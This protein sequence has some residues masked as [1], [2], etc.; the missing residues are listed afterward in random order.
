[1]AAII[2]ESERPAGAAPKAKIFISYSR[3]DM[4][5][6]DRL[7]AA[8]K[9]R[10]FK[11]LIDREE[12][13]AFEDWWA[14]LQSLIGQCDTVIFVLSPDSATSREALKELEYA[15]SLNKRFAP[16]VCRRVEEDAVP[17]ALRRLNFIFFDDPAQ[18]ETSADYL[19]AALQIDIGWIRQHTEFSEA[20]RRWTVAGRPG[21][22]G[23]LLRSPVLEEAE[24]WIASRPQ[25]APAP[26]PDT[27]ALVA[28]S[29]RDAIRRR[30]RAAALVSA[31]AALVVA[32]AAAWWKENWLK[33]RGYALVAVR[34]LSAT[35]ERALKPKD[36]FKECT[37][38]PEMVVVPAGSF[39]MG[40][41][42]TEKRRDSD[43]TPLHKVTIAKPFAV[44]KFAVTVAEWDACV[45]YGDCDPYAEAGVFGRGRQPLVNVDWYDARDYVAWL[46]RITGKPYRLLTEAEYE[47]AARA[48]TQTVYPW[49]DEIGTG[50][51]SCAGCGGKWDG[52]AP[53]PVGSFSPNRFGLYDMAGNVSQWVEDCVHYDYDGAPADGSAWTDAACGSR[54]L[55]GGAFV[56]PPSDERAARR[57]FGAPDFRINYNG[58]RIAR[59]LGP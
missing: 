29:R 30:R 51:A 49:G 58:F 20:A 35:K 13:Y 22:R 43:E 56:F 59:T 2:A 47:Y 28:E 18:F 57:L 7:E 6:A 37:D 17:E 52:D 32:G 48:G 50:N 14:R 40:S 1:M 38:C 39:M 19:A 9:A 53:A 42:L 41:P 45:A 27:L 44:A 3:K 33:E 16:V 21:P 34:T 54:V 25:D 36:V 5:F 46:S 26:T 24:R 23:L 15:S 31:F 8:L 12:I 4:A 11:V 10:G 55:R